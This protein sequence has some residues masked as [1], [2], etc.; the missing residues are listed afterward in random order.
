MKKD[1]STLSLKVLLRGNLLSEIKAPVVMETHG[2]Y[3]GVWAKCYFSLPDG[4]VME[5]DP[6]KAEALSKQRPSWAVYEC[7]CE[8]A[9]R[10]GAGAHL[11]VNFLDIDPYGDPW[12]VIDAFFSS[13]RT[14]PSTLAIA[15]NDGLRQKVKINGG[16]DVQSLQSAVSRYGAANTYKNY[17]EICRKLIQEKA[18]NR[19]YTLTRWAGYY[20]GYEGQM[21]H[22]AAVLNR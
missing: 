3:G 8:Q 16:W 21:T 9:L 15:V 6:Q 17:L 4:V 5:K 19:G 11:P 2:G 18:G 13:E 7:D 12:H 14:F 22:Y 20:C 10:D 1:N